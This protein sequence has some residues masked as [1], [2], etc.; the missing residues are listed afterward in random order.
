MFRQKNDMGSRR[1]LLILSAVAMLG[2]TAPARAID[3]P[4]DK[5]ILRLAELLGSLHYLRNLCG[6]AQNTWRQ[7]ME[8]LI[9]AENPEP[10][11]RARFVASFNRGFRTFDSIYMTCTP[12]A[13]EAIE[14]YMR[15]GETLTKEIAAKFGN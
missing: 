15:E 13:I 2:A 10:A 9:A 14:R 7:Q 5:D 12:S 4:Y 8:A 6:E 1:I 3:V 11:R